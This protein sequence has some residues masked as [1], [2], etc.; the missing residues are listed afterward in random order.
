MASSRV[1]KS[2]FGPLLY[3]DAI[4]VST[5]FVPSMNQLVVCT[6]D[7]LSC[8]TGAKVDFLVEQLLLK[9]GD[10][11]PDVLDDL[12]SRRHDVQRLQHRPTLSAV[13]LST[14]SVPLLATAVLAIW[15]GRRA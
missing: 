5:I 2:A 10:V 6:V 8:A 4:I 3:G 15:T 12:E 7:A 1:V 11:Q 14:P 9:D 13:F